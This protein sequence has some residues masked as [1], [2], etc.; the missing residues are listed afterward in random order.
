MHNNMH[1]LG[2]FVKY[3]LLLKYHSK[4][5]VF[6]FSYKTLLVHG[7]PVVT[8]FL[9]IIKIP[10]LSLRDSLQSFDFSLY[11]QITSSPISS[12]IP[13]L[14]SDVSDKMLRRI[15]LTSSP[16]IYFFLNPFYRIFH[17]YPF[18]KLVS[19]NTTSL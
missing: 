11:T 15:N 18:N 6:I 19:V 7:I 8:Y 9:S 3:K 12:M 4:C 13:V 17:F 5:F 1:H 2:L 16:T 14:I 10:V